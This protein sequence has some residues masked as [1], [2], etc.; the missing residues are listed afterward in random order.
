MSGSGNDPDRPLSATNAQYRAVQRR[1]G[2]VI[3]HL[4]AHRPRPEITLEVGE[5]DIRIS[6]SCKFRGQPRCGGGIRANITAFSKSSKRRRMFVGRNFI[7]LEIMLTLTYPAEFRL[8]GTL[9]KN[10]W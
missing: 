9:V 4:S 10:H 8:D 1:P 5:R 6:R 2:L 3:R 7:G